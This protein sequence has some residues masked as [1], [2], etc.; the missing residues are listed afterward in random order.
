MTKFRDPVVMRFFFR[1]QLG[2][3]AMFAGMFATYQTVSC[4]VSEQGVERPVAVAAGAAAGVAPFLPNRLF[5]RSLPWA[6]VLVGMDV[7]SGGIKS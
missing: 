1:Q 2:T 4:L 3:T 5:R 6:L 7:Y